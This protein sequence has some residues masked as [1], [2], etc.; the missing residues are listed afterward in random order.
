MFL[1]IFI[2]ITQHL[3]GQKGRKTVSGMKQ[4]GRKKNSK[5]LFIYF[6]Q[7]LTKKQWCQKEKPRSRRGFLA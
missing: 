4:G 3:A 1:L 6:F 7:I 5:P 2:N